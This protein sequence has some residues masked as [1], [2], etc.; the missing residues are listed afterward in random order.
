[1][2]EGLAVSYARRLPSVALLRRVEGK[3]ARVSPKNRR[4]LFCQLKTNF[5]SPLFYNFVTKF[6]EELYKRALY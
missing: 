5:A 1:M 2:Y 6:A 3:A 4:N